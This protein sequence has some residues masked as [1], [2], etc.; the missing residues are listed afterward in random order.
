MRARAVDGGRESFAQPNSGWARHPN[1]QSAPAMALPA[2]PAGLPGVC[3]RNAVTS[4]AEDAAL[5]QPAQR[6]SHLAVRHRP[7][8]PRKP[9]PGTGPEPAGL[10]LSSRNCFYCPDTS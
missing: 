6:R 2:G 10:A 5:A 4:D 3:A 8:Q 9:P 7:D 1:P